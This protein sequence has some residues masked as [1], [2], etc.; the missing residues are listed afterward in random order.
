M[1][2]LNL[3]SLSRLHPCPGHQPRVPRLTVL[4][5]V[6]VLAPLFT[7]PMGAGSAGTSG[8]P[9]NSVV[10]FGSTGIGAN[11]LKNP[12]APVVGMAATHDGDGYWLVGSDGGDLCLR[13]R[14]L[15]RLDRWPEA[16]CADR[17]HGGDRGRERVLAGGVG[18]R[19]LHLRRRRFLR[20]DRRPVPQRAD[21]RD[22]GHP[23]RQG[24]L[25]R[26]LGRRHLQL[27]RRPVLRVPRRAAAQRADRRAWRPPPTA[28]ATGSSPRTAASSATATPAST[29]RP[30][31]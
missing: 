3:R 31:G 16:Q 8:P 30:A 7:L 15:L 21:R 4:C 13:R 25:A 14:P 10:A 26:R 19:H 22:G 29:A 1:H 5:V 28:R 17:R 12:A 2:R 20:L 18:R 6:A 11:A 24:L 23:R 9:A 27:R